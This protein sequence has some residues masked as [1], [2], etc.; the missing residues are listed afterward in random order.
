MMKKLITSPPSVPLPSTEKILHNVPWIAD[1]VE[2][3]NF[4]K[5]N[6]KHTDVVQL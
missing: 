2:L 3:V 6:F 1:N 4:I 5:V